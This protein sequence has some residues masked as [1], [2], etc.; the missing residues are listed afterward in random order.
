MK[1]NAHE[2]ILSVTKLSKNRFFVEVRLPDIVGLLSIITGL[3]SCNKM[4]ILKGQITTLGGTAIDM[5]E[6]NADEAPDWN[7]FQSELERYAQNLNSGHAKEVRAE[8]NRKIIS[9]L[10]LDRESVTRSFVTPIRLNID[11]QSSSSHTIVNIQG[12]ETPAFLY[13]LTTALSLLGINIDRMEAGTIE[14]QVQDQLWLTTAT[15]EKISSPK[16]LKVIQWA[17]LLMKEFTH[18]LP[19]TPDPESA[20]DAI[21]LL[22]KNIFERN[23]FDA[24]LL[25][26]RKSDALE[27]LARLLGSSRFLW[28]EFIRSQNESI[29]YF[30]GDHELLGTRKTKKQM[31]DELNQLLLDKT[32]FAAKVEV[33]NNFKD[34]EMFR[35]DLRHLLQKTS[36]VEEFAEE[37]SDLAEVAIEKAYMLTWQK[38]LEQ[39]PRPMVS[40]SEQSVDLIC[41]LGKFG[42]RELGYAS[43]LELIFIYTD[44]ANTSS[45]TSQNNCIF[46]SEMVR[47][48]KTI[49]PARSEGIFEIDLRLRPH[50][51]SGPLAASFDLFQKYYSPTGDAWNFER[52]ALVKLRPITGNALL[53]QK[54]ESVRDK[55]VY[56]NEPFNFSEAH[57]LKLREEAELVKAG[58]LNAKYSAG[59]LHDVEYLV[60]TLQILFGRKD[61]KDLRPPKTIH[62]IRALHQAEILTRAEF[63]ALL[64]SYIFLR[65]LI[66]ALRV[67]RGNAK[68][69]TLP[70]W[71]SDE[72]IILARRMN[73]LNA[74]ET[75]GDEVLRKVFKRDCE[76]F[77]NLAHSLYMKHVGNRMDEVNQMKKTSEKLLILTNELSFDW[78]ELLFGNKLDGISKTLKLL[79]FKNIDEAIVRLKRMHQHTKGLPLFRKAMDGFC[80]IWPR[81]GDSDLALSNLERFCAAFENQEE[82]WLP[83][84]ES[85]MKR[86]IL[87]TLFGYSRYL[88]NTL[89]LNPKYWEWV[90]K[91]QQL[92]WKPELQFLTQKTEKCSIDKLR[93]IRQRETLRIALTEMNLQSPLD[94]VYKAFSELADFMIR[95]VLEIAIPHDDVCVIGLGKLGGNELNFS[96]DV[97]LMF[98]AGDEYISDRLSRSIHEFSRLMRDG[99]PNEFL[100]RVD[101]RLRPNGND[102]AFFLNLNDYISYYKKNADAWEYQ[103]LIKSRAV[104]GNE[105]LGETLLLS[106]EPFIFREKWSQNHLNRIR[107]VKK[108]YEENTKSRGESNT[109]IKM[110]PGGIRDVEFTAQILQL[111]HGFEKGTL[112]GP[113]TLNALQKIK[114]MKLLSD[115]EC[116]DLQKAYLFLRRIENRIQ[117]YE[118]RQEFNIP[119]DQNR[120]RWLAKTLDFH[121][122]S[123]K[124]AEHQFSE[125]LNKI[126]NQARAIFNRVFYH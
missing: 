10:R 87:L 124:R 67:V 85:K 29:H 25:A 13:E 30:L 73:Y 55:F 65:N 108:L 68:D 96:S 80:S 79:D 6:V 82:L 92:A 52:Q 28:E 107:E 122:T 12:D 32:I 110:G 47:L 63:N 36:Y 51:R 7:Q 14:N 125:Q 112:K 84:A 90:Q 117:L 88:S 89:I 34:R 31:L 62:A 113:N 72:L 20:L 104:G 18:L 46:Y 2:K 43:D 75:I 102:G 26:L 54:V 97:D 98:L 23:D 60:Q 101:L 121:D 115:G 58:T 1:K 70:P 78:N 9:L 109:N 126:R 49:L 11:Q 61:R 116:D 57:K 41:A 83:L 4:N 50:G 15:G 114:R 103:A 93:T 76:H 81:I 44:N 19:K 118:N 77:M 95:R 24:I 8:L 35:I 111:R 17:I 71:D 33:L 120:L 99:A 27:N 106:L 105:L 22:G 3:L 38:T 48:F 123:M 5:F 53:A 64:E 16:Q 42:G 37:L 74:V 86:S 56:G 40:D 59:G 45:L 91:S 69:L 39:H 66:N 119:T 94:S 21:V 100:Y